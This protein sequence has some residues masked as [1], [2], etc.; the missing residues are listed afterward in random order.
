MAGKAAGQGTAWL[1]S[2]DDDDY[3]A[4]S[5][6]LLAR[7][8]P[9]ILMTRKIDGATMAPWRIAARAGDRPAYSVI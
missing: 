6:F 5:I 2:F 9:S 3:C 8:P 4:F 1:L 7:I